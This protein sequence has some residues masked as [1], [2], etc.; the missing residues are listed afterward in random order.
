M[1]EVVISGTGL[2]TP[3]GA[4]S[5]DELVNTF[6]AWV[7]RENEKNKEAIVA[8]ELEPL[9]RSSSE[10]IEKASG[11]V[12]RYVV[13]RQGVLDP[14]RMVPHIPER[15]NEEISVQCEMALHAARGALAQAHVAPS[16]VDM[17]IVAC[18][19]M[20]RPYPAIAVEIQQFLGGG[21]YGYDM[22][23]A[24]SSAT[25]GINS[26]VDAIRSGSAN[27]VLMVN[28]EICSGH[29]NFRD[30]DSHFIFGDACTAVLLE[31]E[32]IAKRKDGYRVLGCHLWTQFSNNIRNNFGFLNRADEAG[33][34]EPDKLFVQNG[35][36][37]FKEVCPRVVTHISE[38]LESLALT[39]GDLSRLW[40]HQANLN[41]NQLVARRLLGR[42]PEPQE[43]PVILNEYANTSSAGSIIAFHKHSLDLEPGDKGVIC[44]FGA[45]YSIGSVVVEKQ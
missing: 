12:N 9:A 17:I 21:G 22:N 40:L 43:A 19:N 32:N 18:S 5:N 26:A 6:N 31:N 28:P 45:G 36:K 33:A 42:E 7:D 10:F 4:I 38:H 23:V 20:Q 30:R 34:S 25:F 14:Q 15:A 8:G 24:C 44:S 39:P 35:R 1:P 13:N 29:L 16:E 11:I 37:V 27:R 2:Y 3:P 41:M